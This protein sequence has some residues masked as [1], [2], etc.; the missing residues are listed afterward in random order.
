VIIKGM[1][2]LPRGNP[3]ISYETVIVL[4][5]IGLFLNY[6]QYNRTIIEAIYKNEK[7]QIIFII[8]GAFILTYLLYLYGDMGGTF[9][10]FAF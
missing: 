8:L 4:I 7:L 9:I 6:L 3:L 5:L 1:F 2:L 10:Y